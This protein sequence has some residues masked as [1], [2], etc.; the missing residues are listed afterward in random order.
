[1]SAGIYWLA[2]YPKSG[3]TWMRLFIS[4]VRNDDD[5]PTDINDLR[6]GSIASARGWIESA[7]EFDIGALS[8]DELDRLRPSVYRWSAQQAE[9]LEYHKVHD[10]Y[11]YLPDGE[12]LIPADATRGALYLIRNPLD[13]AV[14]FAH[15]LNCSIDKAIESM[16]TRDYAFC[17]GQKG[18]GNQL[19]QWLL[20]WSDHVMSWLAADDIL[21]RVVRYEDMV[22]YPLETFSSVAQFLE[23][24]VNQPEIETALNSCS[25][26]TLQAQEAENGFREKMCLSKS[27]FRRG[28]VGD[29]RNTLSEAQIS[30]IISDHGNVMRRFGYL[31]DAERP[32]EFPATSQVFFRLAHS[33]DSSRACL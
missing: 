14:S 29:W 31:D 13:V 2:S 15:H 3:N 8:H 6:T 28:K 22:A 24:G 4:N 27:F 17:S 26:E 23:L 32:M 5:E 33:P 11:T 7:V 10:A 9:T 1:M 25:I 30:R 12:A 18:I 16:S 19:R 20:S 21:L